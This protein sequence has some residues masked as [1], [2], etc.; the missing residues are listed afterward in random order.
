MFSW[1][2]QSARTDS[3][4]TIKITAINTQAEFD[5]TARPGLHVVPVM[6]LHLQ[7]GPNSNDSQSSGPHLA[8]VGATESN[9]KTVNRWDNSKVNMLKGTIRSVL[10]EL[11]LNTSVTPTVMVS[12][13]SVKKYSAAGL[14]WTFNSWRSG[15]SWARLEGLCEMQ[16]RYKSF[17]VFS[18]SFIFII[19]A[20]E[21]QSL[22]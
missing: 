22:H 5:C 1:S 17:S 7:L 13:S 4:N 10:T 11:P 14:N 2:S 8:P 12:A 9:V 6:F 15:E 18:L 19:F 3:W 20:G 21:V 16:V